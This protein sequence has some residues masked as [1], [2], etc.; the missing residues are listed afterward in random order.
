MV[1]ASVLIG[2]LAISLGL[3]SE[4]MSSHVASVCPQCQGA[5]MEIDHYGQRLVGCVEC[6]RW[7]RMGSEHAI[8]QLPEEDIDALRRRRATK[9]L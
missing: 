3:V 1:S 5:L 4:P 8:M 2:T 7:T 6:N 9:T